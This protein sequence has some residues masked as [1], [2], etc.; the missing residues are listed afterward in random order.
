M[1]RG[2]GLP[3]MPRQV[4]LRHRTGAESLLVHEAAGRDARYYPRSKVPVRGLPEE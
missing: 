4:C 3:G 2:A 1:R